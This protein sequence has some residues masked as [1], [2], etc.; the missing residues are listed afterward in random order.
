MTRVSVIIPCYNHAH[1]LAD[2]LESVR[3]QTWPH[4]ET[5]V[6]DDGSTDDPAAVVH[7]FPG[8]RLLSQPNQGLSTARNT[9]WRSS[10]GDILIF[11]DADDVL[12]PGAAQTA[13]E[14]LTRH[15][16]AQMTFGRLE[17]MD[18][19]GRALP[20]SLPVV[21]DRFY[22]ELL[23][24]N[25]IR[26][27][28]MAA[29]RREALD[30]VGGFDPSCSPSAD[31]DLYLRIARHC[32]IVGHPVLVARYRQHATNMSKN[33]RLMLPA[34]LMV[35]GRQRHFA[36]G[37][38]LRAA[39]AFGLR[40]CREFYGEQL[41]ERFRTA[42]RTPHGFREAAACAATLLRL[43]PA[44]VMR[45]LVKKLRIASGQAGRATPDAETVTPSSRASALPGNR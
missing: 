31:Y 41:V 29:I 36:A 1:F 40:R 45:H 42:L 16:D 13:V 37:A 20:A 6:V 23:R 11:L 26:T 43:Y 15:A 5:I 14:V 4:L 30:Q 35:L 34:T 25:Y 3:A 17:L 38:E 24:R 22:E 19:Q 8:V 2:A 9:G 12:Y 28:G 10:S 18:H 33:P 44:G 21:T 27:P 7:R 39:L 32:T